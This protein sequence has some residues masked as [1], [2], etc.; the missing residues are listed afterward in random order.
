MTTACNDAP[1]KHD[2]KHIELRGRTYHLR[3]RVPARYRAVDAR[4]EISRSLRTRDRDEARRR[5]DAQLEDLRAHWVRLLESLPRQ[6]EHR[7]DE[8]L[9]CA[10]AHGHVYH[11]LGSLLERDVDQLVERLEAVRHEPADSLTVTALLGRAALPAVLVSALPNLRERHDLEDMRGRNDRQ[12]RQRRA[13]FAAAARS[14]TTIIAD[15]PVSDIG[16]EEAQAYVG[17]WQRRVD[18][19]DVTV[20]HARKRVRA[21]KQ[22]V[23]AYHERFRV[24]IDDRVNPFGAVRIHAPRRAKEE[25]R[26]PSLPSR[27][28]KRRLIDGEGL[29]DLNGQASAMATILAETG[30]HLTELGD[31]PPEHVHL[32]AP[33]PHL[34]VKP[35]LDGPH[36]ALL[37][38]AYSKRPVALVGTSLD[39]MRRYPAGFSRYRG[40]GTFSGEVNGH[41]RDRG[42]FPAVTD[43]AGIRYSIGGLRHAFE[44]RTEAAGISNEH[45]AYLMGHSIPRV[46]GRAAYGTGPDLRMRALFQEMVAFPTA[47]WTPRPHEVLWDEIDRL[48]K[49]LHFEFGSGVGAEVTPRAA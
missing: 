5:R 3:F 44:D 11:G 9:S 14:F 41:L 15:L 19:H 47:T 22:L 46:R 45:R 6:I 37:K 25:V 21:M 1:A 4:V 24:P 2:L 26:K 42:L 13:H 39:A 40:N 43:G 36:A 35:V 38:T 10:T 7:F 28:I 27:W 34:W 33:V 16:V 48:K 18:F 23:H 31:V 20:G 17:Y 12:K 30:L 32:E 29:E 49:T 8:V